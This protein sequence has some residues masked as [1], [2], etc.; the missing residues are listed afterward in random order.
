MKKQKT[1]DRL[2]DDNVNNI[3]NSAVLT[4]FDNIRSGGY[5][6]TDTDI[7]QMVAG[8][9]KPLMEQN[10]EFISNF[11][12]DDIK[13]LPV[14]FTKSVAIEVIL[15]YSSKPK[16]GCISKEYFTSSEFEFVF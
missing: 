1:M 12:I 3:L 6:K 16:D 13:I 9:V 8:R 11:V 14:N 7:F 15:K 10:E 4:V 2:L 5:E